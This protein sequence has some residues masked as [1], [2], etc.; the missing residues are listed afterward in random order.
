[1]EDTGNSLQ[2][3]SD[4]WE[5]Q[6]DAIRGNVS[7]VIAVTPTWASN[8]TVTRTVGVGAHPTTPERSTEVDPLL[9]P[10]YQTQ[11]NVRPVMLS[12]QRRRVQ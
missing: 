9:G 8:T 5:G 10:F 2:Q 6:F 7:I 12:E 11:K 3:V 1:M 4:T